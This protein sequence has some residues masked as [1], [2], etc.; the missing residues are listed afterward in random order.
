M[1]L[2][3]RHSTR[4]RES[5]RD[6]VSSMDSDSCKDSDISR[7]RDSFSAILPNVKALCMKS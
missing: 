3:I 4:H 2:V 1:V 6:R 5:S 7:A